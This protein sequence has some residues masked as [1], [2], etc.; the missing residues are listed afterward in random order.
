MKP[1]NLLLDDQCDLKVADF[2]L[3]GSIVGDDGSGL[4]KTVCGTRSYMAPELH[5]KKSYTGEGVDMFASAVVL[6]VM[7]A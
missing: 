7:V 6:F 1:E 3:C 4:L 2:G 5:L